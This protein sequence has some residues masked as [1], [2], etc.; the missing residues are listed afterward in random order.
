VQRL[1]FVNV[2]KELRA[3]YHKLVQI[4]NENDLGGALTQDSQLFPTE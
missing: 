3:A 1:T 4:V 2:D